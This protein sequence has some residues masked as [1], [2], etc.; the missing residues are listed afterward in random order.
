M[1]RRSWFYAALI[2]IWA[3]IVAWQVGEHIR[4]RRSARA[5]LINRTKDIS[6]TLGLVLRSQRRFGGV[7]SKERLESILSE[8]VKPGEL[9]AIA[10]L[11]AG[12]EVVASAGTPVDF[13]K[14]GVLRNSERWDAQTVTLMNLI[15]LGTNLTQD[16]ERPSRTIVV[17]RRELFG[18]A[19]TN[20]PPFSGT[21]LTAGGSNS[22]E[23]PALPPPPP[24]GETSRDE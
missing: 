8:L 21:N 17:P 13:H 6:N 14:R 3:A 16:L 18:P 4:V 7:I 2:V 1:S 23:S 20:R 12:G 11:N 22:V 10:L 9:N 19:E 5:A 15:D 24:G